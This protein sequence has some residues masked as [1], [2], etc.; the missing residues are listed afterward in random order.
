MS[1][2]R[3]STHTQSG[4]SFQDF[5]FHDD[6]PE[7]L[8]FIQVKWDGYVF[9][10]LAETFDFEDPEL[11]GGPVVAQL[12][13]SVVG[14]VVTIESWEI[15]WRDDWPLSLAIGFLVNCLPDYFTST[16]I[17]VAKNSYQFWVSEGFEPED[18]NPEGYLIKRN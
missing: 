12:D 4:F 7:Q 6:P 1:I 18:N 14:E 2:R 15:N 5:L 9:E 11:S 17:R 16:I 8:R 13:Y 3:P 10:Q